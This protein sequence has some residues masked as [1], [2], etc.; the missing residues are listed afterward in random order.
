[1][2]VISRTQRQPTLD[3]CGLASG[4]VVQNN[5]LRVSVRDLSEC[6]KCRHLKKPAQGSVEKSPAPFADALATKSHSGSGEYEPSALRQ[7]RGGLS[8]GHPSLPGISYG[9]LGARSGKVSLAA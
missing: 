9:G 3:P 1:M 6:A 8:L 5:A 2:H 4:R 7:A